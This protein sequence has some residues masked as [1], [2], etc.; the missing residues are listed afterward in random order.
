MTLGLVNEYLLE[1]FGPLG[2]VATGLV[3]KDRP[4]L[5]KADG[6]GG[7]LSQVYWKAVGDV[8]LYEVSH[9]H[10]KV[11]LHQRDQH[12]AKMR[13]CEFVAVLPGFLGMSFLDP[14]AELPCG[15]AVGED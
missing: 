10:E 8:L 9:N 14:L 7:N 4:K 13:R 2:A 6:A 1:G 11:R 15:I 3:F 5:P 12:L